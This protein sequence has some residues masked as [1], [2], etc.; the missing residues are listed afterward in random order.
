[1]LEIC[2]AVIVDQQSMIMRVVRN[3]RKLLCK[4]PWPFYYHKMELIEIYDEHTRKLKC[5]FC[6]AYFAMSD[7]HQSVLPWDDDYER[8][9]CDMYGLARTKL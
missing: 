3:M 6:G 8:I 5:T 1:M 7:I 4:L 9:T 2:D